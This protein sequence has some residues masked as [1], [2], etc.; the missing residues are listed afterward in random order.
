MPKKPEP[1]SPFQGV[2]DY[3]EVV[4]SAIKAFA[5]GRDVPANAARIAWDFVLNVLCGTFDQSY[6]PERPHDTAFV[7]GRRFVGLQLVKL[8]NL[9]LSQPRETN[10]RSRTAGR[11]PDRAA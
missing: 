5:S 1:G 4:V 6:R 11:D 3:D 8:R 2:S 9:D 7:E 10:V